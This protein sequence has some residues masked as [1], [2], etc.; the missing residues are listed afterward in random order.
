MVEC[1]YHLTEM[2]F[3]AHTALAL[4]RLGGIASQKSVGQAVIWENLDYS[5]AL[6]TLRGSFLNPGTHNYHRACDKEEN[7]H[8]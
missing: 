3:L 6:D 4:L 2:V 1:V 7:K 5:M 8:T